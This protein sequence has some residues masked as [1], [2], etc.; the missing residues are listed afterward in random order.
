MRFSTRCIISRE[1]AVRMAAGGL[2]KYVPTYLVHRRIYLGYAWGYD[3][4]FKRIAPLDFGPAL[5]SKSITIHNTTK[6][7]LKSELTWIPQDYRAHNI[8]YTV[9]IKGILNKYL[10]KQCVKTRQQYLKWTS[11]SPFS[12]GIFVRRYKPTPL[13]GWKNPLLKWSTFAETNNL[14]HAKNSI[15]Y[16]LY[17]RLITSTSN[18]EKV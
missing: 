3:L 2:I 4:N 1:W 5:L 9:V 18:W 16:G 10:R 6:V 7:I 11:F 8:V 13:K 17:L 14:K 12:E 15:Y